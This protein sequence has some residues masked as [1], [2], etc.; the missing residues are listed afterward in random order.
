MCGLE[1]GGPTEIL[2]SDGPLPLY[3]VFGSLDNCVYST[4]TIWTQDGHEGAAFHY[5]PQKRP[6]KQFICEASHLT[7]GSDYDCVVASHCLEHLAN[8]LLALSEWRRVLRENGILLLI[9]PHKDGTFDWRRPV[10]PL[11]HMIGDYENDVGEDDLT[12]LPEVLAL[13]DLRR[14]PGAG[15]MEAFRERCRANHKFRAM[16]HHVFDTLTALEI[17]NYAGFTVVRADCLLPFHIFIMASR[18]SEMARKEL[19]F[20]TSQVLARSP[21]PSDQVEAK[22]P[23]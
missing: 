20:D 22:R 12:H 23:A 3:D 10:T 16:H 11:S 9:L 1:I 18:D 14:D 2:A 7:T 5:H 8:P 6:G 19:P 13:H 17:V 4:Q 15:T 21:F